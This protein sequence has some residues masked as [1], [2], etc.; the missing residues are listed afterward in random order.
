M[1]EGAKSSQLSVESSRRKKI[2][3]RKEA[4]PVPHTSNCPPVVQSKPYIPNGYYKK[5]NPNTYR[6]LALETDP[7]VIPRAVLYQKALAREALKP[8]LPGEF[9]RLYES[10]FKSNQVMGLGEKLERRPQIWEDLELP[11]PT[12]YFP[13]VKSPN[14]TNAPIITFGEREEDKPSGGRLAF[15]RPY[16]RCNTPYNYKGDYEL[17]WPNQLQYQ[18]I[19]KKEQFRKLYPAYTFGHKPKNDV[20]SK[21]GVPSAN[22]YYPEYS[23]FFVKKAAPAYSMAARLRSLTKLNVPPPDSYDTFPRSKGP[24]FPFELTR[25]F[26]KR[27]DTGPFCAS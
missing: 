16:M 25:R 9:G 4:A 12:T 22:H 18:N 24:K 14:E 13:S 10:R 21:R 15:G 27:H 1:E 7:R 8:R 19:Y 20:W 17:H 3:K 11:S 26:E 6:R 2:T 23:D 5:Y